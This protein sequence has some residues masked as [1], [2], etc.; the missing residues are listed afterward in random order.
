MRIVSRIVVVVG[1]LVIAVALGLTGKAAWDVFGNMQ[2]K[3]SI[4]AIDPL[5]W[6]WA[7]AALGIVGGFLA[8][9]GLAMPKGPKAPPPPA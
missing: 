9:L 8:G 5:P 1:L 2:P 6:V 4:G 3:N 7:G